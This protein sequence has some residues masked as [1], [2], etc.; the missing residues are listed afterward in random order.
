MFKWKLHFVQLGY[1][2]LKERGRPKL[3]TIMHGY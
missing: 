3:Q 2:E 1:I